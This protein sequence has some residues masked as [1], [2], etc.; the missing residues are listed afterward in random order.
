MAPGDRLATKEE[1]RN[2]RLNMQT[3]I[4]NITSTKKPKSPRKRKD[5]ADYT[6]G[7]DDDAPSSP[8]A[9]RTRRS[10]KI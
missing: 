3:T 2:Y 1:V 4:I 9:K 10:T 6:S 8:P 7:D 5:S